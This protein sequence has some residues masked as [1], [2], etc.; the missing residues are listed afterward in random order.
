MPSLVW[1]VD[2]VFVTIGASA[3]RYYSLFFVVMLFGGYGLLRGQIR[4]GGGD[5]E[6]AGDFAAYGVPGLLIGARLGHVIFYDLSKAI[7]D[8]LWVFRVWTGG[9]ASHG[10]LVGLVL[11]M[12]LFT[13]RRAMPLLEGTDR[14]VLSAALGAVLVRLGNFFNSEIV[15]KPT[16][17]S[18]GVLFPRYDVGEPVPRHPTQLY[19]SALGVALFVLLCVVDRRLGRERRP[20]GALTGVFLLA[21]FG[22]RFCIEFWKEVEGLPPDVWLNWGQL[23]SLPCIVAGIW[24]L[25]SSFRERRPSGWVVATTSRVARA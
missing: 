16:D 6:E 22:G 21:Y 10:A 24:I 25:R 14:L 1:N 5:V 7:D 18:W 9:L 17:G 23:L 2:P 8:P 20:R 3:L 19:E 12:A 4:R 15:G 11:A 13:R